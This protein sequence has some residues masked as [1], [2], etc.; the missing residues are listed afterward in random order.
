MNRRGRPQYKA[1]H[2][3]GAAPG[4]ILTGLVRSNEGLRIRVTQPQTSHDWGPING[5][6]ELL[7]AGQNMHSAA[8]TPLVGQMLNAG[9]LLE[10]CRRQHPNCISIVNANILRVLQSAPEVEPPPWTHSATQQR[11]GMELL[12]PRKK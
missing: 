9:Q 6:F 7:S 5:P 1:V 11:A 2:L 10:I 8:L 12:Q 4:A 3:T